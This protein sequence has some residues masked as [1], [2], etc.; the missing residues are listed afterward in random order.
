MDF[1]EL[2]EYVARTPLPTVARS[3]WDTEMEALSAELAKQNWER[4]QRTY[5]SKPATSK[6]TAKKTTSV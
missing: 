5:P 2:H 1:K 6:S 3:H 4:I